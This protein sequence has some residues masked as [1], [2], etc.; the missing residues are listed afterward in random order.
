MSMIFLLL[1]VG[2]FGSPLAL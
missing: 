2:R 1:V